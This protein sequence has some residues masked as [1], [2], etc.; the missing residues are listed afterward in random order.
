MQE[1]KRKPSKTAIEHNLEAPVA[2][3][4]LY[5]IKPIYKCLGLHYYIS[6]YIYLVRTYTREEK[7]G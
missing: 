7:D 2:Q 3:Y 5:S 1:S 4:E 6:K